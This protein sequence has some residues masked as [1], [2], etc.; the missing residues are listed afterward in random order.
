MNCVAAAGQK[1][2]FFSPCFN[3][4]LFFCVSLSSFSAQPFF[5]S[6]PF[7]IIHKSCSSSGHHGGRDAITQTLVSLAVAARGVVT[8]ITEPLWQTRSS[9]FFFFVVPSFC[10]ADTVIPKVNGQDGFII[11]PPLVL[12][13]HDPH[14]SFFPLLL[15]NKLL[16][17]CTLVR[18]FPSLRRWI[19]GLTWAIDTFFKSF[20]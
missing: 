19:S 8:T 9:F 18:S 11:S 17:V 16:S 1:G 4:S 5:S 15:S 2:A 20:F 7:V 6:P 13:T 14:F 12:F 10:C 3:F